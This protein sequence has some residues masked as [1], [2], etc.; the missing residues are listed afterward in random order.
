M[1][2]AVFWDVSPCGSYSISS[3]PASVASYGER[4]SCSQILV[5][6]KMEA[7]YSPETSVLTRSTRRNIR[8]DGILQCLSCFLLIIRILPIY[9]FLLITT[10][11]LHTIYIF[12]KFTYIET[13][14]HI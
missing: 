7:L 6:L 3:Q 4:C 2:N 14:M 12:S 5:T 13:Y 10:F 9:Q 1:K 8:E 11:P